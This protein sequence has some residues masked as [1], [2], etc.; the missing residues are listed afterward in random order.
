MSQLA[1]QLNKLKQYNVLSIAPGAPKPT[2]ILNQQTAR[3]TTI[4]VL[5]TMAIIGYG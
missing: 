2:L 5:L 4:D 3:C 1:Q